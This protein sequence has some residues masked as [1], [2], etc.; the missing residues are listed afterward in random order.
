LVIYL[1]T[2]TSPEKGKNKM[3]NEDLECKRCGRTRPRNE[4]RFS[5]DCHGIPFRLVCDKCM[6]EIERT[7]G[8]D[9]EYYSEAD[10]C[11]DE[12]Y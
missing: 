11:I 5:F 3:E 1:R 4:M 7:K 12:D 10:E 8:Y 6:D 9:G 2:G